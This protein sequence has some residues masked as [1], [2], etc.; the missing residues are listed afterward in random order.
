[1]KEKKGKRMSTAK[2]R[3]KRQKSQSQKDSPGSVLGPEGPDYTVS[4]P[5]LGNP[6]STRTWNQ[7]G[8]WGY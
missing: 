6:G 4:H 7:W 8:S 2:G 5:K 3:G 1:M